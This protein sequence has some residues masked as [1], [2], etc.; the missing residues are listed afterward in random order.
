MPGSFQ[1][2]LRP[3]LALQT[4]PPERQLPFDLRGRRRAGAAEG[5]QGVGHPQHCVYPASGGADAFA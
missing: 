2:G 3:P 4:L 1:R 5:E